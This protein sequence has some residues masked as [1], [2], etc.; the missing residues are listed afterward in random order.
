MA[1]RKDNAESAARRSRHDPGADLCTAPHPCSVRGQRLQA[2]SPVQYVKHSIA[3]EQR[4]DRGY[5]VQEFFYWSSIY[6]R[7]RSSPQTDD[8]RRFEHDRGS[9]AERSWADV[10]SDRVLRRRTS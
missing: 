2:D 9:S 3:A 4:C 10:W 8:L 1:F 5:D 7:P 6:V